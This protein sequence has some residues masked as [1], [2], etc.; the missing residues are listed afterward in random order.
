VVVVDEELGKVTFEM[1]DELNVVVFEICEN[2]IWL[3]QLRRV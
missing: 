1:I 3:G 2:K